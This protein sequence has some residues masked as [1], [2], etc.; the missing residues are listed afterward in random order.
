MLNTNF[1]NDFST[2]METEYYKPQNLLNQK[3]LSSYY[4]YELGVYY[5]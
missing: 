5:I 1:E 4:F 2:W 3:N